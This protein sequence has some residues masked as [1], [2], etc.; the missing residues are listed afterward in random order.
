MPFRVVI[1]SPDEHIRY[2]LGTLDEQGVGGGITARVRLAHALA[3]L[4]HAVALFANVPHQSI[5]GGVQYRRHTDLTD[6]DADVFVASTSGG[7]YSLESLCGVPVRTRLRILMVHGTAPPAALHYLQPDY[8]YAPS[9]FIRDCVVSKW[10]YPPEC[11]FVSPRGVAGYLFEPD[12]SAVSRDPFALVYAG[13]PSKGLAAAVGVLRHLRSHDPRY[14]LH[15]YGGDGLWGGYDEPPPVE[16]GLHYHGLIGQRV[17]ARALQTCQFSMNLQ[18]RREPFG[19]VV[20]DSM[21]AGCIVI[22]SPVGAY[23]ELVRDGENGFLVPGDHEDDGT[24]KRTAA[25]I[26]NLATQPDRVAQLRQNALRSV[27]DWRMVATV[28]ESHWRWAL[29]METTPTGACP[30]CEG[31]SLQ[32]AD[33][34][35]CTACGR[36]E[37]K[38]A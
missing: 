6:V 35:H 5:S 36:Y 29:D 12:G 9:N 19:M 21:R 18:T 14:E 15:V 3:D 16:L 32:L 10:G 11:V 2:D 28:W 37:R 23:P 7:R 13:H 24:H 34:L 17:L 25:L 30:Y 27:L 4:G 38:P 33:G 26:M 20:T 8:I 31:A 1:Y 22:A